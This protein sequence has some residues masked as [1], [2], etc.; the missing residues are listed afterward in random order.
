MDSIDIRDAGRVMQEEELEGGAWWKTLEED[1]KKYGIKT[2]DDFKILKFLN[3]LKTSLTDSIRKQD[4]E[5]VEKQA[6]ALPL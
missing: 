6:D 5:E 4:K 3:R 2:K 1:M